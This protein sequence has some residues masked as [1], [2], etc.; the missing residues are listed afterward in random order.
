MPQ[1]GAGDAVAPAPPAL[2]APEPV[3]GDELGMPAVADDF[4][5][6]PP[7]VEVISA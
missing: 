6:L 2:R 3:F 1:P 5:P 4:D 7:G